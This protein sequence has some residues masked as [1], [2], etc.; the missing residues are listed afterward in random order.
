MN[1]RFCH[2]YYSKFKINKSFKVLF[3]LL[4][5]M[6]LF[7][8]CSE[9]IENPPWNVEVVPIIFSVITPLQVVQVYVGKSF[10]EKDDSVITP[11]SI[12]HVYV[13]EKD[14]AWIELQSSEN[15]STLFVDT[16]GSIKVEMGKTYLLKVESLGKT[17]YAQTTLP[18]EGGK[19]IDGECMIVS[20]SDTGTSYSSNLCV[21]NVHLKLPSNNGY[22]CY[23]TAFSDQIN[24][25]PFL[26][27]EDYLD[28]NFSVPNGIS[29]FKLN[30]V[31][32]DPYLKK[33]MLAE[34]VSSSMFDSD[35]ITDVLTS[36]GGVYPAFSNIQNGVGL[37]GSFLI[38]DKMISIIK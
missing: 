23:L 18:T 16:K 21:F 7:P 3:I 26:S 9:D 5:G 29:S 28:A 17:V 12:P 15:D 35:D 31:T 24:S 30:I 2:L 8:S 20:N 6:L 14:S 36:Y 34:N 33:F 38:A 13:S 22:G 27:S 25:M 19:I 10:S 37:F 4:I 32:V 11:Y 1:Y